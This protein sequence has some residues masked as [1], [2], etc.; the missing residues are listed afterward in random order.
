MRSAK[1]AYLALPLLV[2]LLGVLLLWQLSA[3]STIPTGLDG[4]V[5]SVRSAD[6]HPGTDNAWFVR[7]GDRTHQVDREVGRLLRAGDRLEKKAWDDTLLINGV[8]TD[9]RYSDDARAARWFVPV[10]VTV[11][12]ALSWFCARLSRRRVS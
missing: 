5:V 12:A 10:L 6:E 7:V 4:T 8:P 2:G 11:A 9:V 1:A 3:R